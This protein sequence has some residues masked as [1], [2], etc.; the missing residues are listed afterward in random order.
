M[1]KFI[2]S[3]LMAATIIVSSVSWSFASPVGGSKYGFYRLPGRYKQ[4]FTQKFYAGEYAR[5]TIEGDSYTDLDLYVYDQY[6]RLIAVDDT[7][8]DDTGFVEFYVP[9][10][11]TTVKPTYSI[12]VVNRGRV[13]NDYK[14]WIQ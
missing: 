2:F 14:I 6:G 11:S 8:G 4:T 13:F 12:V 3:F 5:V 7:Y 1:K 10:N 9:Y